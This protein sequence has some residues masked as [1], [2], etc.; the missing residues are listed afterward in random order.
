M[1]T[2]LTYLFL[3]ALLLSVAW[4]PH[5]VGQVMTSGLL[6]ADDYTNLRQQ[7]DFPAWV[8]RA[9]RAHVNLVEQFGAFATL[10]LIA[11]SL[12][13]TSGTMALAAAIFFWARIAHFIVFIAGIGIL[14]A[15]TV[16][17]TIA[18]LAIIVFAWGLWQGA[19]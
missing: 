3:S 19:G 16:I 15:R 4:I 1:T 13:I 7:S 9:N 14:M 8:R 5:I 12:E 10:V 17:F 18:W 2:E 11:H 6:T